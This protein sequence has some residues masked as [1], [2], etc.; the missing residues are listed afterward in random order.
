VWVGRLLS[1]VA[2]LFL[3]VDTAMK[4][5]MVPAAVEASKGLGYTESAIFAIGAI[6]TVCLLLYVVPRTAVF[7]AV[8]WTGYL[9]GAIA[10]HVRAGSPFLSHILFPV[11]VAAILWAGLWFRDARTRRVVRTALESPDKEVTQ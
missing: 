5:F 11:Y 1:A 10:T 6:E 4:L 8:L 3:A 7:G 9:G 2:L